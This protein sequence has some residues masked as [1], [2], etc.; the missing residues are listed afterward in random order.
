M[1]WDATK[2]HNLRADQVK[3]V[4]IQTLTTKFKNF[5][6]SNTTTIID[7][8]TKL[9]GITLKSASLGEVINE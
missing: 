6:M 4:R 9:S 3:K 1:T 8:A 7:F 2:T 5:K